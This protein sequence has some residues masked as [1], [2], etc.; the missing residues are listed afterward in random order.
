MSIILNAI[1]QILSWL[2]MLYCIVIFAHGILRLANADPYTSIMQILDRLTYPVY[3]YLARFI[4]TNFNGLDFAP[5]I[6]IVILQF[7][8]LTLVRFLLS[9]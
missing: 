7:I 4:K 8:N 5:L 2:I 1:G 9:F 6:C 3:N